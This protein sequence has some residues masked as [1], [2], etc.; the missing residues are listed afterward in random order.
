[1]LTYTKW[2]WLRITTKLY[3]NCL[4]GHKRRLP[5]HLVLLWVHRQRWRSVLVEF[6]FLFSFVGSARLL[7]KYTYDCGLC[8]HSHFREAY[9][10]LSSFHFSSGPPATF[11]SSWL[12]TFTWLNSAVP[13][14]LQEVDICVLWKKKKEKSESQLLPPALLIKRMVS[15][16]ERWCFSQAGVCSNWLVSFFEKSG[17]DWC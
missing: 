12:C 14:I 13:N 4:T 3:G 8:T 11:W 2:P 9:G 5:R 6:M 7:C 15:Q 17:E 1:M 16:Q 10:F